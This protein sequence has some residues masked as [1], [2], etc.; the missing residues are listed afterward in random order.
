MIDSPA[1]AFLYYVPHGYTTTGAALLGIQAANE[2][3]LRGLLHHGRIDVACAAVD[4]DVA[5]EAFLNA[6]RQVVPDMAVKAVSIRRPDLLAAGGALFLPGPGLSEYAWQRRQF[7][8]RGYSLCGVTHAMSPDVVMDDVCN[9]TLAPVQAWDALVCTST[10]IRQMIETLLGDWHA[11]LHERLAATLPPA[12]QMPLIPL[13]IDC[14]RFVAGAA[15]RAEGRRRLGIGED[16]I[17]VLYFGRLNHLAK[18]H[19]VPMYQAMELAAA[20]S[21][22]RLHLIQAGWFAGEILDPWFREAARQTCPSVNVTFLDGREGATRTGI[23]SVA[24]IFV[25]LADNIQE[26][27]GLSPIEAMAAGLPVVVSDW[28][29]Y[30]ETVRHGVDGFRIATTMPPPMLGTDLTYAYGAERAPYDAYVGEVAQFVSVDVGQAAAALE[31]LVRDAALRRRMGEAGRLRALQVYDWSVIIPAYQAL[32]R[33]LATIRAGAREAVRRPAGGS[34]KPARP[35]PFSVFAGFPTRALAMD[36]QL[37]ATG[38]GAGLYAMLRASPL[39]SFADARLP[40]DEECRRV[41]TILDLAPARVGDLVAQFP[42]DRQG[43]VFRGL[44][45]MAKFNLLRVASRER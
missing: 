7:D 32:W 15:N 1:N 2:G 8:Q 36:D 35:D 23:W 19:P 28:D 29:G 6:V 34:W 16:D 14:A 43:V 9:F 21:G 33:E 20:T 10:S 18:A 22:K 27:F 40:A 30:R 5:A 42:A 38:A 24:D 3:F 44:V 4:D 45:W 17:A 13:G 25:S 31:A 11:Y 12:P 39:V 26:S 37:F 41:L